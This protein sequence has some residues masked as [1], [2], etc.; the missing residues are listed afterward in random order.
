[1]PTEKADF[2]SAGSALVDGLGDNGFP[3]QTTVAQRAGQPTDES[4]QPS[5]GRIARV[6][7][8]LGLVNGPRSSVWIEQR[9]S[10]PP[11]ARSNRAGG[12]TAGGAMDASSVAAST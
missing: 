2:V 6:D 4:Q 3:E 5:C 11:V 10:N 9:T 7:F 12:A 1:V 8:D